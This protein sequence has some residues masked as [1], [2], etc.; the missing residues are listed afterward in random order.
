MG[1]KRLIF[2][3]FTK[4]FAMF[5]VTWGHCAQCL[6]NQDFPYL[7]GRQGLFVAFHMPM[8]MIISGYFIDAERIANTRSWDFLRNKFKRLVIPAVSWYI[9]YCLL[10][11]HM[12]QVESILSFYWFLTSMFLSFSLVL[13]ACK[14]LRNR[15]FLVVVALM[16]IAL[17]YSNVLNINF[18][19]P[20]MVGGGIL[21]TIHRKCFF[22]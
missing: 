3:D 7:F 13:F 11:L 20:M 12:P 14:I 8:F 21:E 19:F 15:C 9:L 22:Q 5:I 6:S 10:T 4:L 17:P 16:V 2:A 1:S 18:M